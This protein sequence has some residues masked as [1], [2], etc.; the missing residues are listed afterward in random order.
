MAH[1]VEAPIC[2][3]RQPAH[4]VLSL[5]FGGAPR[6]TG[7]ARRLCCS[8]GCFWGCGLS[9]RSETPQAVK[10]PARSGSA[11][12]SKVV[13]GSGKRAVAPHLTTKPKPSRY[14]LQWL[15][16]GCRG[17]GRKWSGAEALGSR[18][19]CMVWL[20]QWGLV[21]VQNFI[22]LGRLGECFCWFCTRGV[23]WTWEAEG[24]SGAAQP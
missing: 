20:Y 15:C 13:G 7:R 1:R 17:K 4:R 8:R 18:V 19:K 2:K 24:S 16:G 9:R 12:A 11:I 21:K 23:V 6:T 10:A 3:R 5:L 22:V 14:T